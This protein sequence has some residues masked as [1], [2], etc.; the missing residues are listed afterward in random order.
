[1]NKWLRRILGATLSL[2]ISAAAVAENSDWPTRP[3]TLIVIAGAGGGSDFTIRA[4]A[5]E[6]EASTGQRFNIVNQA[7][8]A[9]VVGMTTYTNAK[10]DGYTLGQMSPFAQYR[11]LGQ[12]EFTSASFTP[13]A[14]FNADPAAIHVAA[15]SRF[16][17]VGQIIDVL[18]KDPASLGISCGGTCNAS[19][20][21]PFVSMLMDQGVD[22]SRINLIPAAGSAAG[23]QEMVSGGLDIVLSSVP[24][25]DAL[26]QSH[27]VRT[28][29]VINGERLE[30]YPGIPTV[31]EQLGKN[32]EGGTWR[33]LAGPANMNPALVRQIE[34]AVKQAYDSDRFQTSMRQRG[35]GLKWRNSQELAAFMK[36]HEQ[37]TQA[38]LKATKRID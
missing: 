3:V 19:W 22:V 10:P 2:G 1:M 34:K 16:K 32:F 6:L 11:L 7:Q 26:T 31:K 14:Q 18:K 30:K 8:G 36:D 21:I 5:R 15:G 33:G 17:D 25:A 9:G 12:A 4:L 24:E 27:H 29:A 37:Q 35:F 23:L 20:D 38:V 13:I 28:I